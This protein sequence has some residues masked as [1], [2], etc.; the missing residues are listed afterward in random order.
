MLYSV[1]RACFG[2][3][4]GGGGGL[5]SGEGTKQNFPTHILQQKA[6]LAEA[7]GSEAEVVRKQKYTLFIVLQNAPTEKVGLGEAAGSSRKLKRK[8]HQKETPPVIE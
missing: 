2:S 7:G 5:S 3:G 8:Q 1:R 4:G 6:G